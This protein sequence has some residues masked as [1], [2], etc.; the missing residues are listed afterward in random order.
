MK[1]KRRGCACAG[2][3]ACGSARRSGRPLSSPFAPGRSGCRGGA[4]A[5]SS[6]PRA[7]RRAARCARVCL[8]MVL[9][10]LPVQRVLPAPPAVLLELDAVRRV[11]LGLLRLV[12]PPLALRAR[13]R[14]CDS[15][16]GGH[17]FLS[18]FWNVSR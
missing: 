1:L 2:A 8:A 10:R 13:E 4:A 18:R 3:L 17:G 7:S 15:D 6:P 11:P 14:D 16:S 5:P 9:A 12:V